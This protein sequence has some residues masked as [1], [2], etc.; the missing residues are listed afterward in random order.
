MLRGIAP[1]LSCA[2]GLAFAAGV[3][4]AEAPGAAA[5]TGVNGYPAFT[6]K[7]IS[8][9]AATAAKRITVQIDPEEQA[10]RLA[11]GPLPPAE[12]PIPHGGAAP[13]LAPEPGLPQPGAYDWYWDRVSPALGSRDGRFPAAVAALTQGPGGTQVAAPRLQ[14]LQ[15]IAVAHGGEILKATIGT[16]V[17]PALVLAV[18]GIE[19]GGRVDAVSTAGAVGL[20]QLIPATADR[21]GVTNVWDPVQNLKGGMAYLRWLLDHFEGDLEL[22]LAGYNAGEQAVARHGGVPPY[23]ETQAY[24]KRIQRLLGVEAGVKSTQATWREPADQG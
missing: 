24:V 8:A 3:A 7:R 1:I 2:A 22:A 21:F 9:P 17:S 16:E 10:R 11:S 4:L 6:F 12:H 14:R 15:E 5:G 18:I 20:M 19:S 23:P 13:G